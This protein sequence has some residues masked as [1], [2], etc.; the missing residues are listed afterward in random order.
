[1]LCLP[2]EP[3]NGKARIRGA[4]AWEPREAG[5]R[6]NSVLES[7]VKKGGHPVL[8]HWLHP[9]G[10]PVL[11]RRQGG[12]DVRELKT[13][14]RIGCRSELDRWQSTGF[15][16]ALNRVDADAEIGSD[17]ARREQF[18]HGVWGAKIRVAP[19]NS[20]VSSVRTRVFAPH[21]SCRREPRARRSGRATDTSRAS[22]TSSRTTRR[23]HSR[24]G[25][26]QN[27]RERRQ[28]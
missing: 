13:N 19:A 4:R 15:D 21:T 23:T 7:I 28:I 1:M 26:R 22:S 3:V 25:N 11:G 14:A 16:Q 9:T 5:C 24:S 6:P 18:W 27:S 12:D 10:T 8:Q 2:S 17:V 20:A